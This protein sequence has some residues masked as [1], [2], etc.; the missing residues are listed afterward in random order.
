M[1]IRVARNAA[2]NC[3]VFYGQT[4]PVYFNACL[5]AEVVDTDYVNVI[6]DISS[7]S[8]QQDVTP[9]NEYEYYRIHYS[10]WRDSENGVFASAQEAADYI[11]SIGNVTDAPTSGFVFTAQDEMDFIRDETNTSILFSNGDH[12]GVNSIKAVLKENGNIGLYPERTLDVELYE[13][14]HTSVTINGSSPGNSAATVVNALNALFTVTATS[15]P[16]A[17]PAFTQDGGTEIEWNSAETITPV[18]GVADTDFGY[19]STNSA[20]HGPRVWTTETINE[21][22]E[23][24]TFEVQNLVSSSGPL[25]G[26]GL[27]S[28]DDG[29]LAE[30]TDSNLSNS[31]HHGYWYSVW[32]YNY[33]GYTSPW[34]TYG[35]N[36]GLIYGPGWNG[37]TNKQFRYSD[38]HTAFRPG[39]VSGN[40]LIKVGITDEGFVGIWYYD[41]EIVD[42]DGPYGAR[43]NDW[44]LMSRSATPMPAGQ[45]GL[46][47]KLADDSAVIRSKPQRFATDPAAPTLYYRYAESPDDNFVYPLFASEEEANWVDTLNGGSGTSHTHQFSDDLTGT[48]WYMPDTGGVHTAPSAPLVPGIT[49][50][51][52]PTE[53]DPEPLPPAFTDTTITVDELS[54]VNYQLSPVDVNYVTT[55]GGIP[56][57]SLIG[58]TTLSGIAPE[59]TG[60][61][62][63]N[64]SDTTTVTVYRTNSSGTTTGTL[65][66]NITNLTLPVTP[67]SGFHHESTS[68]PMVD[69]DTLADGSVV[70][71]Q[72]NVA[73]GE[74]IHFESTW[75]TNSMLAALNS[76][77]D[78]VAKVYMGILSSSADL[79]SLTEADFDF[80]V[81]Y[82]K[83]G[84]NDYRMRYI[85][86][87]SFASNTGLGSNG[88]TF[89]WELL[90]ANDSTDDTYELSTAPSSLNPENYLMQSDG[91]SW[92]SFFMTT[93]LAPGNKD[94]HIGVTGTTMDISTT[95]VDEHPIPQPVVSTNDTDWN[96]ALDFS[97]SA[98]RTEMVSGSNYYNPMMMAGTNN[99]VAAPTAGNTVSS[100]HPWATAVVFKHDANNS[101]QHIWNLGEGAGTNDD[102]I[103]LRLAADQQL[104]F[105]WGRDGD[106]NECQIGFLNSSTWGGIYIGHNG[107][108]F[109]DGCTAAQLAS[110]FDIRLL[111]NKSGG[112]D[113]VTPT[114][115]STSNIASEESRWTQTGGRMNR[116]YT[117]KLTLGGRGANRS[118][119]GKIASFVTT[120]LKCGVAMPDDAEILEMVTDPQGW[121]T[122]Y[123]VRQA[124]PSGG[125]FRHPSQTTTNWTWALTSG[126]G[127]GAATQI[128][129]MGDGL[130]DSYS[131]MIRNQV[132][133][134][135]QNYFKMNMI[136]MV[137]NDIQTV[138]IPGLT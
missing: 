19:G 98:E 128:W 87:G 27:Y 24:F 25:F 47:V 109:G 62:V 30:I 113:F 100:G 86:G 137:S 78:G 132:Y 81:M 8:T 41:Q 35:S 5:T 56:N 111:I 92:S 123:R 106:Y 9:R 60:N 34:T 83:N 84:S 107:A 32:L 72:D 55:I 6:N 118:Y 91:G 64:P 22:G 103:Y 45:Y 124:G 1:A 37:P 90:F 94:F 44:I 63:D 69:S 74:R 65:T 7:A 66:I 82:Y 36:S 96:K 43:S 116:Q 18:G 71:V 28:V 105:G 26:L 93:T 129:L 52:I 136:S 133:P 21:P 115:F 89:S 112:W 122:E 117:G 121:L 51:E 48:T 130:Y 33:S 13:I 73:D 85:S 29:D 120:T 119:N 14:P 4:N 50:T 67:I 79:S 88:V 17:V 99:Q 102:N 40:A 76:V 126:L 15:S 114:G 61:N 75:M 70:R 2:G 77:G 110:A 68:A 131:N 95:G 23:Y 16:V 12:H 31:G 38:V 80:G 57:W 58:G 10:E 104:Y 49:Y 11:N 42:V 39:N 134:A 97:G 125:T 46:L 53:N 108:R 101:N 138:N 20:Y 135:D 3:L 54:Q 127:R 59:V